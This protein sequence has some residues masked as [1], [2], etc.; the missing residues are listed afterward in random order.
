MWE[1]LSERRRLICFA[2]WFLDSV[3]VVQSKKLQTQQ[4]SLR[5]QTHFYA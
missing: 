1:P 2:E 4:A 5:D 3:T